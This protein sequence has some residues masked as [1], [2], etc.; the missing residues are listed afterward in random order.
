MSNAC[1]H[2]QPK[3]KTKTNRCERE[4]HPDKQGGPE[5][6]TPPRTPPTTPQSASSS[7]KSCNGL[8]LNYTC[9]NDIN[10]V[11]QVYHFVVVVNIIICVV[12]IN[13]RG[14]VFEMWALGH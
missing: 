11:L 4:E 13:G 3:R 8:S 2:P 12:I 14:G 6:A 10:L 7:M 1:M 9:S 5:A